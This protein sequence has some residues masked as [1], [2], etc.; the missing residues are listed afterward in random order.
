[1]AVVLLTLVCQV[2]SATRYHLHTYTLTHH[3]QHPNH[4]AL[5]PPLHPTPYRLMDVAALADQSWSKELEGAV[6]KEFDAAEGLLKK[7]LDVKPDFF[8]ALH[9]MACECWLAVGWLLLG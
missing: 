4:P 2:L 8:D 9:Y 1:M 7:A 3:A 5:H 6:K